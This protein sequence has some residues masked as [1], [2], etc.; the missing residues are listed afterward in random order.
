MLKKII[1]EMKVPFSKSNKSKVGPYALNRRDR[2]FR[3]VD[4]PFA[5]LNSYYE[6]IN[7][8]RK[9]NRND[10]SR[11]TLNIW[12]ILEIECENLL[13]NKLLLK[14]NEV[15]NKYEHE[16]ISYNVPLFLKDAI[17]KI[18]ISASPSLYNKYVNI[19]CDLINEN[20]KLIFS[21]S[22][23]LKLKYF[24]SNIS[25]MLEDVVYKMIDMY[26]KE[27]I[28][29]DISFKLL[30]YLLNYSICDYVQYDFIKEVDE[31]TA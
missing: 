10:L 26:Y 12:G 8:L 17:Y 3:R 20:N 13:K 14:S 9:E 6:V 27:F 22:T 15:L 19:E 4:T 31:Y 23:E 29:Y 28:N 21:L 16:C 30:K 18:K 24:D 7:F 11:F 2:Y 25:I 5:E 1:K